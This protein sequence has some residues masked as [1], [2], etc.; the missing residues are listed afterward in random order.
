MIKIEGY[1]YDGC[2][3]IQ[4]PVVIYFYQ[5]GEVLIQADKQEIKTTIDQLT[6]SARLGNTRRNI[7]LSDGAKL[8]TD[9]NAA[10]DQVCAY[11]EKNIFHTLIHKL[12]TNWLHALVALLVTI[13]F[14]WGGIEYGVPVAAKWAAKAVPY[15]VEQNIGEQGLET[16]DK[17]LFSP[18]AIEK[19]EQL[20]LQKRFKRLVSATKGK[21]RYQLML[22]SSKQMGANALALP[23]GIIIMTDG[24]FKLAE[25]EEQIISVLTHEIG[26]VEYQHGLRSV[27]QDS[28]TALFMAGLLGDISS[29]T[30][31]S[32]AIPTILVESRY[33]REFEIEA[34]Q[35][36]ASFIK[37]QKMEIEDLIRI[38]TLL[39][40][41]HNTEVEF[42]YLSSHPAMSKRI[43]LIERQ[44][45]K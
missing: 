44:L 26:H 37:A 22:R 41:T 11:F 3:S 16:L 33:S 19:D 6:I 32:V 38:L 14:V 15:R 30:S 7:F 20:S 18:S 40:Q 35:Y 1:Y 5:S 24:L 12:E 21:Y 42:D 9:D 29:V 27:F 10:V 25:N 23:G 13:A 39:E 28:M 43:D 36:A 45:D 2:S 34:D 17:W 4:T 31:L 8:E